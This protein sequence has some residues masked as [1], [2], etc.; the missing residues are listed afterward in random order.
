MSDA[1]YIHHR[2]ELNPFRWRFGKKHHRDWSGCTS[3]EI[4]FFGPLVAY[5]DTGWPPPMPGD[6]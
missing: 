1:R 4:V 2:W 6:P 5:F 3:Y